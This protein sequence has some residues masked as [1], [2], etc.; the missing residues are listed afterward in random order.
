MSISQYEVSAS[1]AIIKYDLITKTVKEEILNA[2][3]DASG[4][5]TSQKSDGSGSETINTK[6]FENCDRKDTLKIITINAGGNSQTVDFA[7]MEAMIS[8]IVDRI[9]EKLINEVEIVNKPRVDNYG[10]EF[11][12]LITTL[13]AQAAILTPLGPAPV[14]SS[15][16]GAL[17][18]TLST[19][20]KIGQA[21]RQ[22]MI[23]TETTEV[24]QLK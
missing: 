11:D 21:T 16:L 3:K 23:S 14:V 6:P 2:L 7:P 8:I 15:V 24:T 22:T 19:A 20:M 9:L 10:T 18:T 17:L 4:K 13:D 12:T 1:K 5:Y